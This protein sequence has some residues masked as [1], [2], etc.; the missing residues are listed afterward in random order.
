MQDQTVPYSSYQQ[1]ILNDMNEQDTC[2]LHCK[3]KHMMKGGAPTDK[4]RVLHHLL[5]MISNGY[6][7]LVPG[8]ISIFLETV[9][10]P[11]TGVCLTRFNSII[12]N[13][14]IFSHLCW[15]IGSHSTISL[16]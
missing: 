2:F 12:I 13:I 10:V 8:F 11:L 3:H 7:S 9:W 16:R 14:K 4:V 1:G 15:V 6:H 5:P